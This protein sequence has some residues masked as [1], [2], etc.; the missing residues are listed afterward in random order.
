MSSDSL[1]RAITNDG[2]FRVITTC[3]T[4][5][6]RGAI[7]AQQ[8][9]GEVASRFAD[10][11]TGAILV[12]ETMSPGLR[13]QG[14]LKGADGSGRFVADSFPDGATRGLVSMPEGRRDVRFGEGALL[15]M[16]RT[17]PNGTL[18]NGIVEVPADTGISGALMQYMHDSEQ[19]FSIVAVGTLLEAGHVTAAGGFIVQLLPEV[20]EGVL[21]VMTERLRDFTSMEPLL[22][23][24]MTPAT[25]LEELLYGMPY[26]TLEERPLRFACQCSH[27]RVV[28]S[29]GTLSASELHGLI[30]AGE[31]L[32]IGC[33]YCGARYEV[34]P[35]TLR[36]LLEKS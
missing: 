5:T 16:M 7:A 14:L 26:T 19:V 11:L 22:R 34:E 20:G 1:L 33:D 17:L 25:L 24:S 35:N 21:A 30:E 6:V 28:A 2:A 12:R 8:A 29:L 36:G 4:D 9:E 18:H 15:Q 23:A 31:L 10:M 32:D 27:V 13:V 3:T